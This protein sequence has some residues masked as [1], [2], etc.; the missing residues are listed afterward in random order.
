[1]PEYDCEITDGAND[2]AYDHTG[3]SA[4]Y[5][6]KYTRGDLQKKHTGCRSHAD[7][8]YLRQTKVPGVESHPDR[9][10][11]NKIKTKIGR[12]KQDDVTVCSVRKLLFGNYRLYGHLTTKLYHLCPKVVCPVTSTHVFELWDNLFDV[13][14]V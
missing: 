14:I 11:K 2:G 6:C 5:I 7:E 8:G 10:K 9:D 1:M 4:E 3:F 12:I 13:N